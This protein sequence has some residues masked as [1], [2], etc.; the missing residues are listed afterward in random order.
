[1]LSIEWAIKW[2]YNLNSGQCTISGGNKPLRDKNK[3]TKINTLEII[4]TSVFHGR[5][6]FKNKTHTHMRTYGIK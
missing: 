1:M 5:I 4:I 2:H 3:T 6:R